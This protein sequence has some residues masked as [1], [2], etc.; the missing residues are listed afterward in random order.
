MLR[1]ILLGWFILVLWLAGSLIFLLSKDETGIF[2]MP[3]GVEGKSLLVVVVLGWRVGVLGSV[4][5][6][7]GGPSASL[8][9]GEMA[10]YD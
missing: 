1:V 10:L 6:L 2:F 3:P 4:I 9:P 8:V 7:E 5:L